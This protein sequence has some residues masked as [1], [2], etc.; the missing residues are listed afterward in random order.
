MLANV[1]F[2][3]RTDEGMTYIILEKVHIKHPNFDYKGLGV[4]KRHNGASA[5]ISGKNL[6]VNHQNM[7]C[8]IPV[9]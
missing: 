6:N 1:R 4:K 5:F 2:L 7:Y 9:R 3:F 8:A